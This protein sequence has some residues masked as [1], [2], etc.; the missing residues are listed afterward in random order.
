MA[1]KPVDPKLKQPPAPAPLHYILASDIE[2]KPLHFLWHPYIPAGVVTALEGD[3]GVGKSWL[4]CAIAT[5]ISRGEPLPG[6][7]RAAPAQRVLMASAEDDPNYVLRPRL[8][9]MGADLR[10]IAIIDEPFVLDPK[11][12]S[13]LGE[14]MR[15]FAATIVFIDPI[16][17]YTAGSVDIYRANEV[18][19]MMTPLQNAA[20]QTGSPLV[21]VR[22][23]SKAQKS[24]RQHQG[25]GSVDFANAVRSQL[26]VIRTQDGPVMLHTKHN[27]S[28][29]GMALRFHISP[30]EFDPVT[31]ASMPG[32]FTWGDFVDMTEFN[33]QGS[34]DKPLERAVTLL[35]DILSHGP[36][37]SD[38]VYK[39]GEDEGFSRAMMHRAKSGIAK[40]EKQPD[41]T[42]MMQLLNG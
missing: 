9:A 17:A 18:R 38:E 4:T 33:S 28:A 40:S 11:G 20:K 32:S 6:Q 26:Q 34:T 25:N 22:H 5:A 14:T 31:N 7:K 23:F 29:P 39:R 37:P 8:E 19:A 10:H 41:G 15:E 12:I 3:G 2:A 1:L 36:V 21:I 16:L 13:K 30:G 35:R 27:Y 42:W 24:E